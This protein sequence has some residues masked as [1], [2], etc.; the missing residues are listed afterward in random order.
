MLILQRERER[1]R[2]DHIYYKSMMN[3]IARRQFG[4]TIEK[5]NYISVYFRGALKSQ[6]VKA[7]ISLVWLSII[8]NLKF[9]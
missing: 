6:R 1:E 9:P 5:L 7:F 3:R 2:E 4:I 8:E